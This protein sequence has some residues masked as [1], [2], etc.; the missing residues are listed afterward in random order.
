[1]KLLISNAEGAGSLFSE[2]EK[3]LQHSKN[4]NYVPMPKAYISPKE[5]FPEGE[6]FWDFLKK[7]MGCFNTPYFAGSLIWC[8]GHH[9]ILVSIFP[10]SAG[11]SFPGLFS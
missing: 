11:P 8:L 5:S 9:D 1:M 3:F 7:E 10:S 6:N 2:G 4:L